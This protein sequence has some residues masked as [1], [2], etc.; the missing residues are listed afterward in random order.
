MDFATL[1]D[2]IVAEIKA[3][4]ISHASITAALIHMADR[5]TYRGEEKEIARWGD[6]ISRRLRRLKNQ[7]IVRRGG[8]SW[9]IFVPEH[10][11][12]PDRNKARRIGIAAI[13]WAGE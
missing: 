9:W 1:D 13:G 2:A 11:R 3:G 8:G 6:M 4:N 7:D 10:L 5:Y 12:N